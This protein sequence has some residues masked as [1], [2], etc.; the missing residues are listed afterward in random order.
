MAYSQTDSISAAAPVYPSNGSAF[1]TV[2]PKTDEDLGLPKPQ[3]PSAFANIVDQVG[4]LHSS[5]EAATPPSAS[6]DELLSRTVSVSAVSSKTSERTTAFVPLTQDMSLGYPVRAAA[7][8]G[9]IWL[10]PLPFNGVI[11]RQNCTVDDT[12]AVRP[13]PSP[14][15][16]KLVEASRAYTEPPAKSPSNRIAPAK[17]YRYQ[18]AAAQ[19]AGVSEDLWEWAEMLRVEQQVRRYRFLPVLDGCLQLSVPEI[20]FNLRAQGHSD[21]LIDQIAR[22]Q[23]ELSS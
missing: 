21:I 6:T 18:S 11:E 7:N 4:A 12:Q 14:T 13:L 2:R 3:Q 9:M 10:S 20:S 1:S 23:Q 17:L 22:L 16:M 8:V 15:A 5:Q 19:S